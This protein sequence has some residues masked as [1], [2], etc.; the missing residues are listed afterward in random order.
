MYKVRA[1]LDWK[2][3]VM[4]TKFCKKKNASP[5]LWVWSL[6][7]SKWL[8]EGGKRL[9]A[10]DF[11]KKKCHTRRRQHCSL[12]RKMFQCCQLPIQTLNGLKLSINCQI[13]QKWKRIFFLVKKS[14]RKCK[15]L[16]PRVGTLVLL[17]ICCRFLV[18][19]LGK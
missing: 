2:F 5:S 16:W 4:L 12:K 9:F 14:F 19:Q 13:Q 17:L 3:S 15:Y 8:L 10:T 7:G 6:Q 18:F 11:N 1:L